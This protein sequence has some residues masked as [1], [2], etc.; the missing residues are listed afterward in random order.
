[1]FTLEFAYVYTYSNDC[2]QTTEKSIY[3]SVLFS[4]VLT[5]GINNTKKCK[6][7]QWIVLLKK[8]IEAA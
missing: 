3:N 7:K 8:K 1:M 4:E 5:G 6:R 2:Y